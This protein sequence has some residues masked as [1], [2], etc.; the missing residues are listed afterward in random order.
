M[1]ESDLLSDNVAIMRKGEIAAFGSPLELKAEHG[2]ALQFSILVD[3][4]RLL[5]TNETIKDFFS[6]VPDK[7]NIESSDTGTIDVQI[8]SIEEPGGISVQKL[9]DFVKWL[10]SKDSPVKE[11]GFSNSSL[12]EVFLKTTE[13]DQDEW[14]NVSDNATVDAEVDNLEVGDE[15]E[16]ND[17][18]S[19]MP[20]LS[21]GI[22][23]STLLWDFYTRSWSWNVATGNVIIYGCFV[24]ASCVLGFGVSR[25]ED[26]TPWFTLIIMF[27][28]LLLVALIAPTKADQEGGQFYLMKSQGLLSKAYLV[29][30]SLYGLSVSFLY[31]VL[32]LLMVY[33]S[34]FREPSICVPSEDSYGY[35]PFPT[36][37]SRQNVIPSPIWNYE[38]NDVQLSAVRSPGNYGLVFTIGLLFSLTMPGAVLA[39]AYLPGY[40]LPIVVVTFLILFLSV[41]P[42]LNG[43]FVTL[44][45]EKTQDCVSIL[46]PETCNMTFSPD[47]VNSDFVDCVGFQVNTRTLVS[48]YCVAPVASMLP[49]IGVY[50]VSFSH[51]F[52][53]TSF[54]HL[55][56]HTYSICLEITKD[57]Y[58][59]VYCR[60]EI[61][62]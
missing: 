5:T 34:F 46:F 47:T 11:Y 8:L 9:T 52:S 61:H 2:S 62:F 27:L 20:N 29:G 44:S 12:E 6:D 55:N 4:D 42:L 28:T 32:V 13:G 49:Q 56:K 41:I 10:D 24:V 60:S 57:A 40:K 7:V 21:L 26:P 37:G 38:D 53:C 18:S 48:Q 22:Q 35:C 31:S 25:Y 45:D 1:E 43:I 36:Y 19:F 39:A 59:R 3:E 23:T 14:A 54:H 58:F 51:L 30:S 15:S 50:Q 16:L 17:I 33:V